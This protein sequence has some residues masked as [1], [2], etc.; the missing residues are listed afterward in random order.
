MFMVY[1]KVGN[2]D[3]TYVKSDIDG[4][5]YLV[6]N[7]NDNKKVAN[8]LASIKADIMDI[9]EYLSRKLESKN[10]SDQK[11]YQPQ[12]QYINQLKR[13]LKNVEIKESASDTEYTSYTVNKGETIVF[14]VRSKSISNYIKSHSIHDKNLVM[15]VALHEISH[16]ACPEYGHTDLFKKIFKFI[17]ETGIELGIYKKLD[18]ESNPIEYCGMKITDSIV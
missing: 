18:F 2:T 1:G 5:N 6:R 4:N 3:M 10:E 9:S 14:C 12:K 7:R 13:N 16:V 11:K 15:Y 17:C 8:L